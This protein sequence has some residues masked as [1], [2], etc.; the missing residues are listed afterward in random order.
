MN[1]TNNVDYVTIFRASGCR[2]HTLVLCGN[3]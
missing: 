1:A 3:S 2:R